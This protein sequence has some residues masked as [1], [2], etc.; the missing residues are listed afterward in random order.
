VTIRRWSGPTT[1][2]AVNIVSESVQLGTPFQETEKSVP[3]TSAGETGVTPSAWNTR[4][5]TAVGALSHVPPC[6]VSGRWSVIVR[7]HAGVVVRLW[8]LR[9]NVSGVPRIIRTGPDF[10][11]VMSGSTIVIGA[12]VPG[13]PG[14]WLTGFASTRSYV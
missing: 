8:T 6:A 13:P 12:V 5:V 7:F 14:R 4:A 11:S 10:S 3:A 1:A 2:A 9:V